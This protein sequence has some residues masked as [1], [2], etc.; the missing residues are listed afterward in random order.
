MLY[1]QSGLQ[2]TEEFEGCS[3][4]SYQDSGGVWTIGWGHTTGVA[5]GMTITQNQADDF[6]M[7]DIQTAV[8]AVNNLVEVPLSQNQFD[9]LVD[10]CFNVGIANFANSTLRKLLNKSDYAGAAA[11]FDNW[12][13]AGGVQSPGLLRRRQAETAEFEGD[14]PTDPT[15]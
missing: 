11:Q 13:Y 12:D 7:E 14:D 10:F 1:S 5:P 2:M 9:A 3:L 8:N 4:T 6:L 15:N